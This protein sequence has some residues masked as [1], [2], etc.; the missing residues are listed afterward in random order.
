MLGGIVVSSGGAAV[1]FE[2]GTGDEGGFGAGKERHHAVEDLEGS[3]LEGPA[4]K[5]SG[6]I[7]EDVEAAQGFSVSETERRTAAASMATAFPP[8]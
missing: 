1:D 6:V 7:Y 8:A 4:G 2:A 5:Y 3:I